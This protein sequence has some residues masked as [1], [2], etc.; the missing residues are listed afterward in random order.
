M[1]V[2]PDKKVKEFGTV[3]IKCDAVA[4]PSVINWRYALSQPVTPLPAYIIIYIYI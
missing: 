4:N 2:S 1:T 3:T